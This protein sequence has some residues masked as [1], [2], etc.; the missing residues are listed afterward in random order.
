M[1]FSFRLAELLNH[2]PDPKK[3]PGTIKAICDFTGLDRHQ[4]SSLLKNEA[5]YIPLSALSQVCDFLIKHGY[6]EANQ[7]PGALFAVEPENFWELL[8]RR[9][10]VEMCLGIRADENWAEG[11]WVVASDSILQGQLLTGI[12]TLGGTAKYRAAEPPQEINGISGDRIVARDAPIP[13]PEDLFQTLVW[14]PGQAEEEEV[15]SRAN[16]VYTSFQNVDGDK[17]LISLGS[18]RSN[19]VIELGLAAAFGAEPFVSLDEVEKPGDRPIPIYLRHREKNIEQPASCCGGAQLSKT[20]APEIPGFYY[21][22]ADGSWDCVKWDETTYEPAYLFYIYHESQGRLEM[23]LGGYSGRGT[24][25][26]A[27]TLSSRPEEF[28]PPVFSGNGVQI[29]AYVIQYELKR[30]K[31]HRSVLVADYSSTTKV[32]PLDAKSIEKRLVT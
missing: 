5:K 6:A 24:R 2:S 28:W 13:Q 19:P 3:R 31:K 26:L 18:I 15:H 1:K 25:L 10:R 11:A 29:G 27:K 4:V 16:E 23:M 32:I 17:A 8:A 9:K 30:Q 14:A 7:L 12:S 22:K 21:E 20:V